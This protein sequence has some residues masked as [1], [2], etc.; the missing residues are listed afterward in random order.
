MLLTA[1]NFVP[2]ALFRIPPVPEHLVILWAFGVPN[3][4]AIAFLI[5]HT[6][7]HQKLNK[8]FA[9]G[10]LL[11]IIALPMRII[12]SESEIWLRFVAMIAP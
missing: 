3:L 8:T 5:W 6:V 10:V 9:A 7:K 11:L 4:V 1:I 12:I 2:A